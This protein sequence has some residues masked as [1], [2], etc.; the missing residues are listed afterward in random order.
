MPSRRSRS[1][2]L[3]LLLVAV[4]LAGAAAWRARTLGHL[5]YHE[6]PLQKADVIYVLAGMRV[7]RA[8][9]AGELY[10]EGWAPRILL[11]RPERD[12]GER[13]LVARGLAVPSE[14]EVQHQA[15]VAMGVP[16]DRIEDVADEQEATASE[17]AELS[18]AAT[19]R[20]WRR[21]IVV[22]SKL[23]TARARL[24]FDRR[25]AGSGITIV[26]RASRFDPSD[27]DRWWTHRATLRFVLF[28]SQKLLVY[29]MGIA[30]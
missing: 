12:G 5:L 21:V 17:T 2:L 26:M 1:R 25:L 6:D 16:P 14:V 30:A 15:L 13:A 24:A 10:L 28:E 7:E 11:S 8:A 19:A 4:G 23:H 9:E 29:W 20:G 27:I 22:T 3:V 18:A